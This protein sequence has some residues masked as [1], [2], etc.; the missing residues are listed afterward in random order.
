MT[1]LP[2][3]QAERDMLDGGRITGDIHVGKCSLVK[4]IMNNFIKVCCMERQNKEG[5]EKGRKKFHFIFCYRPYNLV[6]G[7]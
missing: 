3:K 4:P 1:Y 2:Y 7:S 5:R 6:W